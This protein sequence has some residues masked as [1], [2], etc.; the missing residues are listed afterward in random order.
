MASH[1][2]TRKPQ[3]SRIGYSGP[4]SRGGVG[5]NL[6]R[7][8]VSSVHSARQAM[9]LHTA[10]SFTAWRLRNGDIIALSR[11]TDGGSDRKAKKC[12]TGVSSWF[13][14]QC[15][16]SAAPALQKSI[17][18][19]AGDQTGEALDGFR[20]DWVPDSWGAH[21]CSFE[22]TPYGRSRTPHTCSGNVLECWAWPWACDMYNN[23]KLV[24][25]RFQ[26]HLT[27]AAWFAWFGSSC[28]VAW[29]GTSASL[30]LLAGNERSW[31]GR[32]SRGGL[33]KCLGKPSVGVPVSCGDVM[34][35]RSSSYRRR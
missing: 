1:G 24:N 18:L 10:P 23:I 22:S 27:S 2:W 3:S 20:P 5:F 30:S 8:F 25:E 17:A 14:A 28:W 7:V 34:E 21:S 32:D 11:K 26:L 6:G 12:A 13:G 19:I 15:T 9:S 29:Q 33:L 31:R 16:A 35:A 4:V